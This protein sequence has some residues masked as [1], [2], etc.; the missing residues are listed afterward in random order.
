MGRGGTFDATNHLP[1]FCSRIRNAKPSKIM[2]TFALKTALVVLLLAYARTP[3][4]A[5]TT[6]PG[7]WVVETNDRTRD[8]TLVKFYDLSDHLVYEERLEGVHL[9]VSRRKH[10]RLLNQ[11][12]RRVT[13]RTLLAGR[14]GRGEATLP[15]EVAGKR[16]NGPTR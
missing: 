11:T 6:P 4:P 14:L 7:Y 16:E 9:D 2:K 10:V 8:H 1:L 15:A 12:L 5:Q 13:E 3:A